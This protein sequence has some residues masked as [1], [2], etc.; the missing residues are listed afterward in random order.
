MI[1]LNKYIFINICNKNIDTYQDFID[2]LNEDYSNIILELSS[3]NINCNN[4]RQLIHK[5]IGLVSIFNNSNHEI[6]YLC[7]LILNIDKNNMDFSLYD[8]Y[9]RWII[10]Y[11][12]EKLGLC[13]NI[14]L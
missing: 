5:M 3:K 9:I 6:I 4:V 14:F 8:E 13:T 12:K 1:T 11:D 7:K 2:T 10:Q